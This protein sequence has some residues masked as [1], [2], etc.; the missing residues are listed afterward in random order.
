MPI[1]RR[2][3]CWLLVLV[4]AAVA[5]K[6]YG[7]DRPLLDHHAW[8]QADTA[9]LA[10]NFYADGMN[11]LRPE[12][13]WG[14]PG[15]NYCETEFPL[16]SYAAAAIYR[17]TGVAERV[18]RALALAGYAAQLLLLFALARRLFRDA[19]PALAA[20]FL[21]ALSPIAGFMGRAFMP[22][23]WV[24]AASLA[25]AFLFVRWLDDGRR[26]D[27]FGAAAALAVA[28]ALKL[29]A[30]HLLLLF[31]IWVVMERRRALGDVRLWLAL[32]LAAV[33][34]AAWYAHAHQ[35]YRE[36]GLTFGIWVAGD[37]WAAAATLF[38]GAFWRKML[39][40]NW[41]IHLLPWPAL[42]LALGGAAA[43]TRQPGPARRRVLGW[44]G[45]A[46]VYELVL[47]RGVF[48]HD[49]YS[50]PLLT[51]AAL[52][53]GFALTAALPL[54]WRRGV[55]WRRAVGV[56]AA[57]LVVVALPTST[58]R[59]RGFCRVNE[60]AAL[61]GAFLNESFRDRAPVV[62][63]NDGGPQWLYYCGRK[64]WILSPKGGLLEEAPLLDRFLR[65]YAR[66]GAR[67][68]VVDMDYYGRMTNPVQLY[69]KRSYRRAHLGDGYAIW[70]LTTP[71]A[72]GKAAASE[73]PK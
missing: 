52:A 4:L 49:Y 57:V 55:G 28:G 6:F 46:F 29:T 58:A 47:A 68:L 40:V 56:V 69:L 60:G 18:G 5:Q 51:P 17:L 62:T 72:A 33:P 23:S 19:W 30:F 43:L 31:A 61:A 13:D 41:S 2:P 11:L 7:F 24:L 32:A 73:P 3:L 8:R 65:R 34:A 59:F 53:G 36:T 44:L 14:G 22:E 64:G 16:Y 66:A 12:V 54:L 38:S 70:E 9:A 20:A 37:K 27:L 50:L 42:V 67:Y 25:S 45:V 21:F 1:Y 48:E 39:L 10:R 71:P 63:I 26:G 35:L 15:P